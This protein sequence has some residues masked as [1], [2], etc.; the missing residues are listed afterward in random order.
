MLRVSSRTN[1][2][3][4]RVRPRLR[5]QAAQRPA[6]FGTCSRQHLHLLGGVARLMHQTRSAPRA[7]DEAVTS[8][9]TFASTRHGRDARVTV[10]VPAP[11]EAIRIR[12]CDQTVHPFRGME[13]PLSL[14]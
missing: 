4:N 8:Q 5:A 7:S 13:P 14:N 1:E 2:N 3:C 6:R 12:P 11:A 10:T 9:S